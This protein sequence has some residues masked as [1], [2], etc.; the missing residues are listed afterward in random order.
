MPKVKDITSR[1]WGRPVNLLLENI[2]STIHSDH[3]AHRYISSNFTSPLPPFLPIRIKQPFAHIP[4]A[5]HPIVTCL[6]SMFSRVADGVR[7]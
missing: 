3:T 7:R 1:S 2:F 6:F 4:Q 5:H